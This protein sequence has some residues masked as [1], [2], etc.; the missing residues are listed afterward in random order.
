MMKHLIEK[1]P[2]VAKVLNC[3]IYVLILNKSLS[4]NFS[5][6]YQFWTLKMVKTEDKVLV[7]TDLQF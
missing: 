6:D 3:M 4:V 2:E 1:F 5:V 7:I